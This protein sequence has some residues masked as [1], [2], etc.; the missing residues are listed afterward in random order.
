MSTKSS[1]S[2]GRTRA[3]GAQR[4]RSGSATRARE[5]KPIPYA[6]PPVGIQAVRQMDVLVAAVATC[7]TG[8]SAVRTR[9]IAQATDLERRDIHPTLRF[10]TGAGLLDSSP[11]GWTPTVSGVRVAQ[12][13]TADRA[14][15]R[16]ALAEVWR[17]SWAYNLLIRSIRP[18]VALSAE[19]L[20]DAMRPFKTARLTPWMQLV[21]WLELAQYVERGDDESLR[22]AKALH[23]DPMAPDEAGDA[24]G[25]E[26][27]EQDEARATPGAPPPGLVPPL[28][29]DQLLALSADDFGAVTRS[30]ATIYEVLSRQ[31][32]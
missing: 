31:R 22:L 32:T 30:L 12:P 24:P 26:Q 25:K 11:A 27:K 4:P 20:A 29:M 6:L 18:G 15:A 17:D 8:R 5:G 3:R 9:D 10:M 21:D 13:W 28:T 19:D 16:A 1:A 2:A 23:G 7:A 14:A